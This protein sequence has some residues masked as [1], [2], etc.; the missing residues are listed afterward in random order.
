MAKVGED[1]GATRERTN[2]RTTA[3]MVV[4]VSPAGYHRAV[5]AEGPVGARVFGRA[6]TGAG[7]REMIVRHTAAHLHACHC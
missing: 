2:E 6:L 1:D 5:L 3:W 7:E 4:L